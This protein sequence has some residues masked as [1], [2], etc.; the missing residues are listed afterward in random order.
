MYYSYSPIPPPQRFFCPPPCVYLTGPG[1]KRKK[2]E[3]EQDLPEGELP[4]RPCAFIGLG[5]SEHDMQ[6]LTL[7]EKVRASDSAPHSSCYVAILLWCCKFRSDDSYNGTP[8]I[9]PPTTTLTITLTLHL[10]YLPPPSPSTSLSLHLPPRLHAELLCSEDTLYLRL[11]QAEALP[12][13]LQGA[14][15]Q[16]PQCGHLPLQA[17]QGHLQTFQ[18]EALNEKCGA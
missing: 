18:E 9:V 3:L 8:I 17:D 12:V 7:D 4:L 16:R 11:G 5:S 1:W 10:P 2:E 13:G 6:R 15:H 14:L